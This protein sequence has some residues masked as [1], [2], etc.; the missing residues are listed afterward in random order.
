MHSGFHAQGG[1]IAH[2][3]HYRAQVATVRLTGP[4]PIMKAQLALPVGSSGHGID[5]AADA[6][7]TCVSAARPERFSTIPTRRDNAL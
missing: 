6:T 4:Q 1:D 2:H 7:D 3:R 5:K